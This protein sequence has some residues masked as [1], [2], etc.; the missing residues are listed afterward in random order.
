MPK[1]IS[2]KT[3]ASSGAGGIIYGI[4]VMLLNYFAPI[5]GIIAGFISGVVLLVLSDQDEEDNMN[6]SPFNLLYF[7]GVAIVSL[8][9]G[10]III[11]YFKT[12]II[13]GTPC[14]PKDFM[15]LTQF[16]LSTLRIP[17]ILSTIT[18]GLIAFSL[19]GKISAVYRYFRGG[20]PV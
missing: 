11:Y 5:V 15:T 12:E 1:N 6:I 20:P 16:I 9:F 13:H 4:V 14:Y 7:A 8:L 10:Y 18:G 3:V 2:I 17:D 19:S